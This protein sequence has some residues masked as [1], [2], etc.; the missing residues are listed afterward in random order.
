MGRSVS[1]PRDCLAV[2]FNDV[3]YTYIDDETGEE[4]DASEFAYDDLIK[5]FTQYAPTLWPSLY[6]ADKWI[7][8]EDHALLANGLVR[9][10]MSEYC[11]LVAYWIIA[12]EDIDH[13]E[14]AAR[15]VRQIEATFEKTF[16]RYKKIGHM[17]NG[18]G[19]YAPIAAA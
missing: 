14:L 1:M 2:T 8:R 16:G 13:P 11:G 7:G 5:D 18:E 10:G 4:V 19:V 17:S 6:E 15:W 12:R 3:E 9:M